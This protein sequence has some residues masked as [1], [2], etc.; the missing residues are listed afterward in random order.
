MP[1][2]TLVLLVVVVALLLALL[3]APANRLACSTVPIRSVALIAFLAMQVGMDP[4]TLATFVLLGGFVRSRPIALRVPPKTD[5][6]G[7]ESGWRL[8]RCLATLHGSRLLARFYNVSV[9]V[10]KDV[11]VEYQFR[12]I[13][14]NQRDV[15]V[16]LVPPSGFD[17]LAF[18]CFAQEF[19]GVLAF[20]LVLCFCHKPPSRILAV[21]SVHGARW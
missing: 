17:R 10:P 19:S 14:E 13:G 5:Q 3:A 8:G 4:R 15:F 21:P 2:V 1:I 11:I 20:A 6:G 16:V 9:Y 18:E 7:G 12:A